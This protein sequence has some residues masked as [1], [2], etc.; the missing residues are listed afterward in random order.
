MKLK[1]G[2]WIRYIWIDLDIIGKVKRIT[3]SDILFI[4]LENKSILREDGL[5]SSR[6]PLIYIDTRGDMIIKKFK[7]KDEVMIELI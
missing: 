4:T 2:D 6:D 7:N 1:V 3:G 5:M